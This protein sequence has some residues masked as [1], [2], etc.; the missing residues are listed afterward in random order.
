M[1]MHSVRTGQFIQS[2]HTN[3][4]KLQQN[5]KT[6]NSISAKPIHNFPV[7][8]LESLKIVNLMMLNDTFYVSLADQLSLTRKK[9]SMYVNIPPFVHFCHL[10]SPAFCFSLQ[11]PLADFLLYRFSYVI[12]RFLDQLNS[13]K[14]GA[15]KPAMKGTSNQENLLIRPYSPCI[16]A[17]TNF[18]ESLSLGFEEITT[19]QAESCAASVQR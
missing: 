5:K 7:N 11:N 10:F 14:I 17:T 6:Q 8:Q 16:C 2:K 1:P 13:C 3:S 15:C 9:Q 18:S 4:H 19:D 12:L